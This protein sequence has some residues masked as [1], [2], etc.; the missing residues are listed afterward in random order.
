MRTELIKRY[1]EKNLIKQNSNYIFTDKTLDNFFYINLIRAIFPSA[2]IINCK[3]EPLSS[4]MSILKNNLPSVPWAHDLDHIFKY[5]DI[6]NKLIKNYN[7]VFPNFIYELS[8]EKLSHEPVK[9][10]K[11]LMKFCNL[12]WHKNCLEFYKRKDLISKTTSN[13]QIRK[14]I[15]KHSLKKYSP[16]KKFIDQYGKKYFWYK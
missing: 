3:R 7:N 2:K 1:K 14:A 4:I 8:L 11:K 10:S 5:F 15:Y 9:E 13:L 16:Y 12:P 6:Y